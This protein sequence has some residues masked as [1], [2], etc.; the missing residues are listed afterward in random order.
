MTSDVSRFLHNGPAR[1]VLAVI[2]GEALL[3]GAIYAVERAWL[4]AVGNLVTINQGSSS[5]WRR[6]EADGLVRPPTVPAD[7]AGLDGSEEVIGVDVGGRPR[8]YRLR[9][10]LDPRRHVLNDLIA[11]TPVSLA[12]CDLSNCVQTYTSRVGSEPLSIGMGGMKDGG[13]VLKVGAVYY[14]HR[15]GRVVEG[16]AD[17]PPIPFDPVPWARTT[18]ADWKRRHPTT[19]VYAGETPPPAADAGSRPPASVP[20][21]NRCEG[22]MRAQT[23]SG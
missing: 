6:Y 11:G 10:L 21:T 18:W 23:E 5:S 9:A 20:W 3:V 13:M 4:R 12:Y 2:A 22:C 8:A 19:D 17:A 1:L 15:T 7:A 16:P 14:D